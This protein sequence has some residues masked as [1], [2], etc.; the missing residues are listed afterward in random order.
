GAEGEDGRW[1]GSLI[2]DFNDHRASVGRVEW[3]VTGTILSSAGDDGQVRLFKQ[4][5]GS[6]WRGIGGFTTEQMDDSDDGIEERP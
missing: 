2:A 3:N 6:T 4:A 5:Y 1:S